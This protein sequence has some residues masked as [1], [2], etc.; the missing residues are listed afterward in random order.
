MKYIVK[1][2]QDEDDKKRIGFKVVNS[3]SN[4]LFVDK[5]VTKTG[6]DEEMIAAAQ[7][8]AQPDIDEWEALHSGIGREWDADAGAFV[9]EPAAEESS[10]GESEE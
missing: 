8:A 9:A 7:A 1:T 6:T 10:E 5:V 4:I 3:K 2:F